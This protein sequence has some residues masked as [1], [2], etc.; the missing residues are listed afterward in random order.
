[1]IDDSI[2][3][4]INPKQKPWTQKIVSPVFIL[5]YERRYVI[6]QRYWYIMDIVY[7]Q[8]KL[9]GMSKFTHTGLIDRDIHDISVYRYAKLRNLLS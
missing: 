3:T 9:G 5:A 8:L 1:M 4:L 2:Q 7:D 6:S